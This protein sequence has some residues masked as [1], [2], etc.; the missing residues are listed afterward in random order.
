MVVRF[1]T[2]TLALLVSLMISV[3]M[4]SAIA[5]NLNEARIPEFVITKPAGEYCEFTISLSP[6]VMNVAKNRLF[7]LMEAANSYTN[8]WTTNFAIVGV[9][10]F[11]NTSFSL[12]SFTR[13]PAS[14]NALKFVGQFVENWQKL[15]CGGR[16]ELVAP[17]ITPRP[18][19]D[20]TIPYTEFS[21]KSQIDEFLHYHQR[22]A[23]GPCTIEIEL[24]PAVAEKFSHT[25]LFGGVMELQKKFR[26]PI[27][28][29]SQIDRKLYILLSRQ[30]PDKE[31]IYARMLWNLRRQGV[32]V[33]ALRLVNFHPN[34][35]D[36]LFSQTGQR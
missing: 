20:F 13:C 16:C 11:T 8:G 35:S 25:D 7:D 5:M 15:R 24:A 29:I 9:N 10:Y 14:K 2:R 23:L 36:Y 3:E 4:P 28:D 1:T 21:F 27:M 31:A 33:D 30:C 6:A 34:I 19:L 12:I 22:E 32:S 17:R 18:K 26:Y